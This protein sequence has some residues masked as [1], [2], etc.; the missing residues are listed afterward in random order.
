MV[1]G[2]GVPSHPAHISGPSLTSPTTE[3]PPHL[4]PEP[5]VGGTGGPGWGRTGTHRLL[6]VGGGVET[7][8]SGD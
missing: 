4:G 6:A 5:T 2:P 1:I 7:K 3:P 8:R